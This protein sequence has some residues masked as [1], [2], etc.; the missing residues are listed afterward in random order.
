MCGSIVRLRGKAPAPAGEVDMP[1]RVEIGLEFVGELPLAESEDGATEHDEV[2]GN[3]VV[4]VV[5][6][7]RFRYE[8]AR[9]PPRLTAWTI[10]SSPICRYCPDRAIGSF[11]LTRIDAC[12]DLL[13]MAPSSG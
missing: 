2:G 11:P 13:G 7:Q 5:V 10:P 4:T 12:G 6:I 8:M 1:S 3:D 9:P